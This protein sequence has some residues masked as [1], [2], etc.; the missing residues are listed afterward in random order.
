M[1]GNHEAMKK[2]VVGMYDRAAPL[3]GQVGTKQFTYFGSLLI[4]RLA[5]PAGAQ[6]LDL[7]SGRGAILLAAAEKVGA[8]CRVV[9]IDLAPR[10]RRLV[11]LGMVAGFALLG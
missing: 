10:R 11:G 4:E 8:A 2:E 7:A 1:S 6:V 9:G 5:L 3:Y